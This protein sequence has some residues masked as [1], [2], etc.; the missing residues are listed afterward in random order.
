MTF[1]NA[2]DESTSEHENS[3]ASGTTY[4]LKTSRSG[5][6]IPVLSSV[7][8]F[9]QSVIFEDNHLLV[10]EKPVC[11]AT[12][13][14]AVG[15]ESL[16]TLACRFIKTKYN[17]P[18]R[19]YLGV[20][21]RLDFPVSGVVVFAKTSKC[22]SRLNEQFRLHAVK[23]TYIALIEG[24]LKSTSGT[25]VDYICED[26]KIRRLWITKNPS[27]NACATP[28]EARLTYRTIKF[29]ERRS[30]IEINLH[31]G[32]KHQI[33]L[34]LSHQGAPIVGDG[35]Y[36]APPQNCPGICLHARELTLLHPIDKRKLT[37]IAP[38]PSWFAIKTEQ[39]VIRG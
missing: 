39:S 14:A 24:R 11:V 9:Q 37:F 35:K 32:K 4:S 1:P 31:T 28:Q 13:G 3:N 19:A 38:C 21:S 36:G 5:V 23:K 2:F 22:A 17:K 30:L 26:K 18:R 27:K 29:F 25:L 10:V 20:V 6:S 8:G 33:R 34:Q 16:F 15:K 12:Q 7:E